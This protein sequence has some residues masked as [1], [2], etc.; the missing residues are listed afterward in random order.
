MGLYSRATQGKDHPGG[1]QKDA[2]YVPGGGASVGALEASPPQNPDASF[3][4]GQPV[5]L[6]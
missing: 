3:P 1:H 4:T 2:Q 6:S 5:A